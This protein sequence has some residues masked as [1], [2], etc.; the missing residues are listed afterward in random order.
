LVSAR[1]ASSSDDGPTSRP[2]RSAPSYI[3]IEKTFDGR[4]PRTW[5]SATKA[6]RRALAKE[7]AALREIIGSVDRKPETVP[8]SRPAT[9]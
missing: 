6:G 8:R 9:A 7:I 2:L 5:I 3:S 4:K 1:Y